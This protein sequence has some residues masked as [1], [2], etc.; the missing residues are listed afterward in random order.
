VGHEGSYRLFKSSGGS[1]VPVHHT[2]LISRV[3]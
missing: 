2:A 3:V 1:I